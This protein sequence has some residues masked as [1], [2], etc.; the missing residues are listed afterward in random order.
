M[1]RAIL[2]VLFVLLLTGCGSS[3]DEDG[4]TLVEKYF[5]EIIPELNN[6][7]LTI[8]GMDPKN[9]DESIIEYSKNIREINERYWEN[10]IFGGTYSDNEIRKWMVK[11]TRGETEW[12]ING[13]DL[14]DLMGYVQLY[15]EFLA[16]DIEIAVANPTEDN[17][18][19]LAESLTLTQKAVEDF[20]KIMMNM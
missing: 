15:S 19:N 7:F 5:D 3:F 14:I 20:R 18:K 16:N 8:I 17:L 11:M 6:S 9:L 4:F 1:K 10:N 13:D 12:I 2:F